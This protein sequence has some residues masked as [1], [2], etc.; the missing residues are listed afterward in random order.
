[1]H[2]EVDQCHPSTVLWLPHLEPG[3]PN[4]QT[5]ARK[6]ETDVHGQSYRLPCEERLSLVFNLSDRV[7]RV[8]NRKC[9]EH[10]ESALQTAVERP[11]HSDFTKQSENSCCSFVES[12]LGSYQIDIRI[13]ITLLMPIMSGFCH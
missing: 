12:P 5:G 7:R 9:E 3:P 11:S 2:S 4:H 6:P 13:L 8:E 10:V 1:M